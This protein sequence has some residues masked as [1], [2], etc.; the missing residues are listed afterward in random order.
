MIKTHP[1]VVVNIRGH[2]KKPSFERDQK[3]IVSGQKT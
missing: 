1:A 2:F 3:K